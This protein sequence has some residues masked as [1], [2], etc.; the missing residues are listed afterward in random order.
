MSSTDNSFEYSA[1]RFCEAHIA[2][3][4]EL[5]RRYFSEPWSQN[6]LGL[7]CTEEYPSFAVCDRDGSLLGYLSAVKALDEL[8]IINV[9]VRE[10]VR[11]RGIGTLLI[12]AADSYCL[13]NSLV[14]IS[15]EVRESNAVAIALYERSG[16]A[17]LG[18]RKNFYRSPTENAVVMVKNLTDTRI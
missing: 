2:D 10:D 6:S 9:A 14:S 12:Q 4:A 17:S 11:G 15:L 3:A 13:E 18:I 7:L 1:V 5:E 8:Q 16:D